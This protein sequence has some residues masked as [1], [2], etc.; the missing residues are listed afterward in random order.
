MGLHVR[1]YVID[2]DGNIESYLVANSDRNP[3]YGIT[4]IWGR[5]IVDELGV[6]W[7]VIEHQSDEYGGRWKFYLR[8]HAGDHRNAGEFKTLRDALIR[9]IEMGQIPVV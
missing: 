9:F 8:S 1:Y 5:E 4:K 2:Y 3:K 7:A 6:V